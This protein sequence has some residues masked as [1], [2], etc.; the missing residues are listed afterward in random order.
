[1]DRSS[2]ALEFA[3]H[4]WDFYDAARG[5]ERLLGERDEYQ[6][7]ASLPVACLFGTAMELALKAYLLSRRESLSDAADRGHDMARH[8]HDASKLGLGNLV[9]ITVGDGQ[10]IAAL[11]QLCAMPPAQYVA[12][13]ADTIPDFASMRKLCDTL[14]DVACAMAGYERP[15]YD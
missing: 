5:A 13:P 1:M 6:L 12:L 7:G 9:R 15:V 2:E 3:R 4:A 14:V 8:F 11:S 10:L